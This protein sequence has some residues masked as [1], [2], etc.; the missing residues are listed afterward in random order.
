MLRL[1][2]RINLAKLLSLVNSNS[3]GLTLIQKETIFICIWLDG[4]SQNDQCQTCLILRQEK[5][6][7]ETRAISNRHIS[8][9]SQCIDGWFTK[10]RRFE[11]FSLMGWMV[12]CPNGHFIEH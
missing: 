2:C 11:R 1:I 10:H 8:I 12:W 5:S 6:I 7:N 9:V 4:W 3:I